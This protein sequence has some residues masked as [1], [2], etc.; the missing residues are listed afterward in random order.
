MLRSL[1]NSLHGKSAVGGLIEPEGLF[2]EE[3]ADRGTIVRE[4]STAVLPAATASAR[5]LRPE[6]CCVYCG[7]ALYAPPRVQRVRCP[8]CLQEM[9]VKDITL[10]GEVEEGQFVTAGKIA[11]DVEARVAA[12]LI[13]CTIEIRG[14][15]LGNVLASQTCRVRSTG[16]LAGQIVCRRLEI[17]PG[18]AVQGEL[19][20]VEQEE[21]AGL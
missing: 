14:R 19:E 16:K 5:T 9:Q 11:V 13:G 10:T 15:V 8:K 4:V 21:E 12:N 18:G 2:P 6:H 7:R 17:E 20:L 3:R 1:F